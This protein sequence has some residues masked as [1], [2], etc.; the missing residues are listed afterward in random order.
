M[1]NELFGL[2]IAG[3]INDN[4]A[5]GLL[6]GTVKHFT[7]GARNP[8]NLLAGKSSTD[9]THKFKGIW[10]NVKPREVDGE[11]ILVTDRKA[12]IIGD[13]I[14]PAI[15]PKVDDEITIEGLTLN[16]VRELERDPAGAAYLFLCRDR[17][18]KDGQ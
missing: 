3:L 7:A 8:S 17:K 15:V 13:S 5:E 6:D 18:G 1:S 9:T 2:D 16:V 10:E 4:L 14:S 12:L 11:N